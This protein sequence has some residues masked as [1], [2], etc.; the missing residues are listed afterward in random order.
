MGLLMGSQGTSVN[1]LHGAQR[2]LS[3]GSQLNHREE[4]WTDERET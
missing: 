3:R 2:P 4:L 1:L